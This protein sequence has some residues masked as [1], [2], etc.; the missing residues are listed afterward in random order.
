M[1]VCRSTTITCF[2]FTSP[3]PPPP[4]SA[5]AQFVNQYLI[6]SFLGRGACGK[7]FLCLN[8]YDLRLYAMKVGHQVLIRVG[9]NDLSVCGPR[10]YFFRTF[11]D[12]RLLLGLNSQGCSFVIFNKYFFGNFG[13]FR[14]V[15]DVSDVWNVVLDSSVFGNFAM[16]RALGLNLMGMNPG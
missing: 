6:V 1:L 2:L 16:R 7:V 12:F 13:H 15:G 9:E 14:R 3:P 10:I 11:C 5:Y 8:T 4:P